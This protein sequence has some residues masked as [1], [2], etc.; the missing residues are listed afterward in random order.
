MCIDPADDKW[1]QARENLM[2]GCHRKP[3]S[4]L[5]IFELYLFKGVGS[6]SQS[7]GKEERIPKTLS[8]CVSEV[9]N[10]NTNTLGLYVWCD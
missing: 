5:D 6:G 1:P 9:E 7:W 3:D 10:L 8:E 4:L 2:S